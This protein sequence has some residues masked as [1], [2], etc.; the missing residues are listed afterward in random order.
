MLEHGRVADDVGLV[1]RRPAAPESLD[2]GPRVPLLVDVDPARLDGVGREVALDGRGVAAD[3]LPMA[4][5][6]RRTSRRP[7]LG[8]VAALVAVALLAA[9]N[10]DP[11]DGR[12]PPAAGSGPAY[13]SSVRAATR[14]DVRLSWREGCPVHWRDLSVI[15]VAYWGYDGARHTG[16][17][18]VHA[19][20]AANVRG[21]F[22]S[23]YDQRFQ[24]RRVHPVDTFGADD[25]RSMANNNTSAF[26]C[27]RVAG[28]STWSEHAYG[29]AIDI[30]PIQN[31]YVRGSTVDPPA[32]KDWTNRG[33]VTP[34]M[35]TDGDVV[36]RAFA[37]K[38][39]KWGGH[40]QS[41]KDYQHL[42]LTGR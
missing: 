7:V 11:T 33:S 40:W 2:V 15:T 16:R 6:M 23:I 17:I 30:N 37:A 42:S 13:T 41:A 20:Q 5:A 29:T 22:R 31:P 36:V 28:T 27:R 21:A 35:I 4:D 25:D 1:V 32:G 14:D 9:C 19:G 26:N 8:A 10:P 24:I 3:H 38:G 34:G 12:R 18:V 39:W